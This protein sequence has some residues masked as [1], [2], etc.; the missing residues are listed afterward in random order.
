MQMANAAGVRRSK[1]SLVNPDSRPFALNKEA[2]SKE[3]KKPAGSAHPECHVATE[4]ST[5][6]QPAEVKVT[7]SEERDPRLSVTCAASTS[8]EC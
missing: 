8:Q 4:K 2:L 7:R 6:A 3:A 5:R 1:A